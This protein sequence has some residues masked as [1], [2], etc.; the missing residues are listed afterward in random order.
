MKKV[1][2]TILPAGFKANGVACGLKRSAKPDLAL[3][4]SDPAAL[5]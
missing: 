5:A 2:R 3:L 4:Y 1:L